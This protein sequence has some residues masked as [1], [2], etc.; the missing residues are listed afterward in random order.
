MIVVIVAV[1]II[2]VAIYN[3][4]INTKS[5]LADNDIYIKAL[6]EKDYDFYLYARYGSDL[7]V[8]KL[9]YARLRNGL[10]TFVVSIIIFFNN[11]TF[12]N[13]IFALI[14]SF[15]VFKLQYIKLKRYYKKKLHEIDEL[16]PYYLK[17]L[18]VLVQHYTIPV[19]LQ[20]SINDA[21]EIFKPGLVEMVKRID[22][23]DSSIEPYVEFAKAY[24]V[25]DSMRMMRLLYRLGLGEQENKQDQLL[26]FSRTVSSLQ[27]KAR[28]TKY[29]ARL[30]NMEK[31]TII[32]LMVTGGG[33]M[34]ILL[35]SMLLMF[36]F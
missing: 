25:R 7:D 34:V 8:N 30:S 5:F 20:K 14:I 23:G 35:L 13:L 3:G 4:T 24:P 26:M 33:T 9:F 10:I 12:I 29:K 15:I 19:A 28:E 32:M 11:L 22:A 36:D 17:N 31:R 27:N 6:K 18:E 16:L 2:F 1:I 21:P